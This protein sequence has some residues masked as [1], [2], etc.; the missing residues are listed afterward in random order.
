VLS[1]AFGGTHARR[2]ASKWYRLG[3]LLVVP[4]VAFGACSGPAATQA[5]VSA[6]PGSSAEAPAATQPPAVATSITIATPGGFSHLDQAIHNGAATGVDIVL[7]YNVTQTLVKF[8]PNGELE[9][10][11]AD[12]WEV[13]QADII[14]FHL[15]QGVTFSDG[16]PWNAEVAR[17]NFDYMARFPGG[18]ADTEFPSVTNVEAVDEYTLDITHD[19]EPAIPVIFTTNARMYSGKQIQENPGTIATGPI[20]SGPYVITSFNPTSGM[21]LEARADYWG[22]APTIEAITYKF[23]PEPGTRLAALQSGEAQLILDLLPDDA[24]GLSSDQVITGP[25]IEMYNLRFDMKNPV[26]SDVRVRKAINLAIDRTQLVAL[27]SG[28]ADIASGN[29]LWPSWVTGWY[30]EP[31]IQQDLAQA[32]ALVEEAGAVGQSVGY[33]TS[34]GRY[35][36]FGEVT[37]VVAS[38]I[39]QTGLKVEVNKDPH[40][41][42]LV[43]YRVLE[44]P[45]W[46]IAQGSFGYDSAPDATNNLR[47]KVMCGGIMSLYCSSTYD[48]LANQALAE[49]D[50]AKRTEIIK[51]MQA[52]IA[53]DQPFSALVSPRVIYGKSPN[54]TLTTYPN[55]F[56]SVGDMELAE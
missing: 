24:K 47:K 2:A 20:G 3:V 5:P 28:L 55:G 49:T 21:T 16:S 50:V 25:G 44:N 35:P 36:L 45:P 27:F 23:L 15:K 11:L 7:S 38:E 33:L 43:D 39:E 18:A 12:S 53:Q 19:P 32:K 42:W 31:P 51:Q 48:D 29:Q 4:A 54:L 1:E 9:P 41:Q 56:L 8:G 46:G 37:D 34:I 30:D 14:R 26:I 40:S 6:Q 17:L 52:I 22:K 10:L 13:P